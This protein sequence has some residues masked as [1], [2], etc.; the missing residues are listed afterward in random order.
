[1]LH[2]LGA[3]ACLLVVAAA[4]IA[5]ECPDPVGGLPFGWVE[6][7]AAEGERVVF[8]R[9]AGVQVADLST[10]SQPV[11]VG[12]VLFP[13]W[14]GGLAVSADRAYVTTNAGAHDVLRVH[15]LS[16]PAHPLELGS[17]ETPAYS[18]AVAVAGDH[19]FVAWG[20]EDVSRGGGLVVVD[21]T[22][23][24]APVEV[25]SSYPGAELYSVAAIGHLAV[26][27]SFGSVDGVWVFD[28]SEPSAPVVVGSYD[29][30]PRAFDVVVSD[31]GAL[32]AAMGLRVFDLDPC[33]DAIFADDFESGSTGAWSLTVP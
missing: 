12:Q 20:N 31:A 8:A 26:A 19:A 15:D 22:V 11:V 32:V 3:V 2:R 24:S 10:P 33:F 6:L 5:Q 18:R 23:P 27:T 30:V 14:V 13:D 29:Q 4:G 16:D 28:V 1:M 7:V 21:V 25:G 17:C 9:G